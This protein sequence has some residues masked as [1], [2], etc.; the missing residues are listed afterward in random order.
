MSVH[1]R[2][3]DPDWPAAFALEAQ[4]IA[5]ALGPV[6]IG[7]HHI[8]ST[9]IPGIAAKPIIDILL[10]VDDLS[11]LD[12]GSA[13]MPSLGYQAMGELGLPGRRYFRKSSAGVRTHHVHGYATG[14]A[15]IERH[16]AFRD[17]LRAHPTEAAA[18][19]A[20]KLKLAAAHPSDREAYQA[21]KAELIAELESRALAWVPL[22]VT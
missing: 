20:L 1:L 8:G 18:Y 6:L 19:E 16:L 3:H 12:R 9:A 4:R 2:S 11:A 17:Y 22:R 13:V 15:D 14:H 5:A 7:C 10:E 21:G